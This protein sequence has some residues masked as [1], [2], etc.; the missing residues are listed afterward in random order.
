MHW[1][2]PKASGNGSQWPRVGQ[3]QEQ[4]LGSEAVNRPIDVR[5]ARTG[6]PYTVAINAAIKLATV[7]VLLEECL[8]CVEQRHAALVEHALLDDLFRTAQH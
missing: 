8:E 7:L 4:T 3:G 2:K 5:A 1:Q 6:H